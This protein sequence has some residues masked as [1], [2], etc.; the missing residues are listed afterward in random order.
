MHHGWHEVPHA[1]G[2]RTNQRLVPGSSGGANVQ[3]WSLDLISCP[4]DRL[5]LVEGGSSTPAPLAAA[6]RRGACCSCMPEGFQQHGGVPGARVPKSRCCRVKLPHHGR[7]PRPA[8]RRRRHPPI[9][10]RTVAQTRPGFASQRPETQLLRTGRG[11]FHLVQMLV[12]LTGRRPP[13]S[14]LELRDALSRGELGHA[15]ELGRSRLGGA[16]G[17]ASCLLVFPESHQQVPL[18]SVSRVSFCTCLRHQNVGCQPDARPTVE[19]GSSPRPCPRGRDAS[20]SARMLARSCRIANPVAAPPLLLR[21]VS[22]SRVLCAMGAS[23]AEGTGH[24]PWASSRG[25]GL[26]ATSS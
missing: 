22:A 24:D 7:G 8:A 17:A 16:P 25:P 13:R 15:A 20:S 18:A 26:D 23:S 6:S 14:N 19:A 11:G 3:R 10:R 4:G 2:A 1:K 9:R 12:G 21:A 5:I